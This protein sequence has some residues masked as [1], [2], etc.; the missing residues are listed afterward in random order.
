MARWPSTE[1]DSEASGSSWW[2]STPHWLTSSWGWNSSSSEGTTALKARSQAWSPVLGGSAT[3]TEL[4][5]AFGPPVSSAKPV[6]GNR[7]S[8]FW[9]M[10]MVSTRGSS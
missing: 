4:P 3:L 5:G 7:V 8:G 10:E 1:S 2:V 6:P 9:C